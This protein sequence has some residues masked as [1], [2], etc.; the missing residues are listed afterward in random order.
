MFRNFYHLIINTLPRP[1][2]IRLSYLFRIFAPVL[3]KGNNV[4]CPICEKSFRKFL[5]Y[6]LSEKSKRDNVLCPH[7]L[8]LERH[9]LFWLYLKNQTDYFT[10]PKK[11][12]HI[13]PEQCFYGRFRKQKNLEYTTADLESPLADLH[14]DLHQIPLEDN[15]YDVIFCNHV[16]EHVE[17]DHQ[18][19]SE[20]YRV[21]K[22]GG[23]AIMQVP[24]DYSR[25]ETYEDKSITDP[26]EREI[27]FW[28]KDHVRLFGKDYPNRLKNAGFQINNN[29]YA[30]Q[31]DASLA[32]RY[33]LQKE[34]LLYVCYKAS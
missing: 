17:D 25:E 13:A 28:Q 7:C 2:L 24:I 31:I 12:L 6:G 1:L 9:R 10:A 27:H 34:E 16:M 32:D 8:S 20:I 30:Q 11:V 22:P 33:R 15:Q 23:F 14:F 18:C 26:K 21:L 29:Q 4:E 3:L 19:M 5:P